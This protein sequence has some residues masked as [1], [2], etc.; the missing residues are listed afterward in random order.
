MKPKEHKKI[1]IEAT[2]IFRS[3]RGVGQ[4]V[5]HI[6]DELFK[7]DH[8]NTF[9][10]YGYLFAGKKFVKPYKSTPKNVAYRLIRYVP[11]KVINVLSRKVGPPPVDVLTF[12]RPDIILFTNF[13]RSKPISGAKTITIIY[14]MSFADFGQFSNKKNN[15]LLI[16]QV[17]KTVAKSDKIITISENAKKEIIQHYQVDATKIEIIYPAVDTQVFKPQP[18][19]QVDKVMKKYKIV[20]DYILYTGTLE[21]RKNIIGILDG[22]AG[23]SIELRSKYTLVLAG[24]KG[25]LDDEIEKKLEQLN[26]LNILRTG[27]VDDADLPVLF[28]GATLF[29]YPSFY[30]GFGM[31]PLEAMCCGVPVITAN[32]SSLPEVVGDAAIMIDAKDT[33]CLTKNIEKV[34]QD[35]KLQ[36]SMIQKG[37]KRAKLFSWQKSAQKLHNLIEELS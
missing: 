16:K 23:L 26:G 9:L 28:S 15:E 34:L 13:V 10:L 25:W 2:P 22:Y 3:R 4:Y 32:N 8:T 1:L 30:E 6:L 7:I 35:K 27:Y 20:Q 18:K 19:N 24:G 17:P 37:Y 5:Y 12:T 11:S 33:K 14:D 21:P 36:Q 29:V 31:P